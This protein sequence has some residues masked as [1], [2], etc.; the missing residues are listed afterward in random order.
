MGRL[1]RYIA[2]VY[3]YALMTQ[4]LSEARMTSIGWGHRQG[5]DDGANQF[6]YYRLSADNRIVFGGYD[7]VYRF[8]GTVLDRL[9]DHPA[10]FAR[11]SQHFFTV[12]P[13]L[14]GVRFTHRWGGAIDTCSRFSVCFVSRCAR[15]SSG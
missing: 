7:A 1:G 12:F 14:E 8:G 4:P 13:Q 9:D 5:L 2:P 11:L 15:R 3:D 6:H 10:T